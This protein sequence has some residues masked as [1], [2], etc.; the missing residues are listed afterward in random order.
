MADRIWTAGSGRSVI[1]LSC[2][3]LSKAIAVP[4][5]KSAKN[6]SLSPVRDWAIPSWLTENRHRRLKPCRVAPVTKLSWPL[7]QSSSPGLIRKGN[8]MTVINT[9][10]SALRPA[11]VRG[12][13]QTRSAP[14]WSVS[15]VASDQQREGRCRRPCHRHRMDAKVRGLNQAILTPDHGISLAQTAEGA[16]GDRFRT[17]SSA[18]ANRRFRPPTCTTATSIVPRSRPR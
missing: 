12:L 1:V 11:T 9:N 17:S 4:A 6:R 13:R 18:C 16:D 15:S 10:V 3:T 5:R 14:R 2:L 7:A 8:E